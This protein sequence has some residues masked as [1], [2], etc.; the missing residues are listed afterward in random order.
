MRLLKNHLKLFDDV[1]ILGLWWID[2]LSKD[3]KADNLDFQ[4]LPRVRD[5]HASWGLGPRCAAP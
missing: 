5:P 1:Y 3:S 4:V 2:E